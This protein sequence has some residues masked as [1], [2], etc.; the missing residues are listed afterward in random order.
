[1]LGDLSDLNLRDLELSGR[2]NFTP[3]QLNRCDFG[4]SESPQPLGVQPLGVHFGPTNSI[5][6]PV[7]LF[8]V[9][10]LELTDSQ[11]PLRPLIFH[12]RE[13]TVLLHVPCNRNC[14]SKPKPKF[15][16]SPKRPMMG[17]QLL[18]KIWPFQ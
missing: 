1:M 4:S 12:H 9:P 2:V 13:S 10:S 15:D 5:F 11:T 17:T 6:V 14:I 16:R 18:L 7:F 3:F 8:N